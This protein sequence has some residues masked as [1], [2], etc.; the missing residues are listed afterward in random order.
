MLLQNHE[1]K[2]VVGGGGRGQRSQVNRLLK[3][4]LMADDGWFVRGWVSSINE[5]VNSVLFC[6]NLKGLLYFEY[7]TK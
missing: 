2:L 6:S 5:M 7:I 4:E 3:S 1:V